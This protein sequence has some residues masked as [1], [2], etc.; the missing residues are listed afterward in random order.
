MQAID[1][2]EM[3]EALWCQPPYNLPES[4]GRRQ[5]LIYDLVAHIPSHIFAAALR[6]IAEDT[7]LRMDGDLTNLRGVL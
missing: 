4:D 1:I 2:Y 5:E 6:N 7:G 3:I